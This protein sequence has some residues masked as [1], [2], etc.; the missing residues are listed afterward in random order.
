MSGHYL[1]PFEAKIVKSLTGFFEV[2]IK[3]YGLPWRWRPLAARRKDTAAREAPAIIACL[4]DE[5]AAWID[6]EIERLRSNAAEL[7]SKAA[8]L[9]GKRFDQARVGK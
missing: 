2:G 3:F 4:L 8:E 5:E 6:V 7:R 9:R 1:G